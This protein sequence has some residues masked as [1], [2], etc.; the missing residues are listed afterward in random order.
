MEMNKLNVALQSY[1]IIKIEN[2]L[3]PRAV[4]ARSLSTD[5]IQKLLINAR[6]SGWY[7]NMELMEYIVNC[8]LSHE[9]DIR[10]SIKEDI[11]RECRVAREIWTATLRSIRKKLCLL[12]PLSKRFSRIDAVRKYRFSDLA[13][14]GLLYYIKRDMNN[15]N[16]HVYV[17]ALLESSIPEIKIKGKLL[18]R[19]ERKAFINKEKK[20]I[21]EWYLD[22]HNIEK[23]ILSRIPMTLFP[24]EEERF[25]V[26]IQLASTLDWHQYYRIVFVYN[27]LLEEL[28]YNSNQLGGLDTT[29]SDTNIITGM[30]AIF[31]HIVTPKSIPF[32]VCLALL[33]DGIRKDLSRFPKIE[34]KK[35]KTMVD[36]A[37]NATVMIIR[38]KQEES[39][40]EDI[41]LELLNQFALLIN[42]DKRLKFG[43]CFAYWQE[44]VAH[45]RKE[46]EKSAREFKEASQFLNIPDCY[47]LVE[48][49][50]D[51]IVFSHFLKLYAEYGIAI[52]V[53]ECG[54]KE[55]VDRRFRDLV[56]K[57]SYV[58]SIVTVLDADAG[59]QYDNLKRINIGN[60]LVKHFIYPQGTLEDLFSVKRHIK[61][62]N[63]LYPHGGSIGSLDLRGSKR[64]EKKINA[65]LWKK[66]SVHFD[67][68]SYAE[69]MIGE[70]KSRRHIPAKAREIVNATVDL[71]KARL[72]KL[73]KLHSYLSVDRLSREVLANIL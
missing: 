31:G 59:K 5:E 11:F 43:S 62:L 70:F 44:Y 17:Q 30:P 6:T 35:I 2:S 73:P 32:E 18:T 61:V 21:L 19:R 42:K 13:T 63:S 53:E 28:T 33:E 39:K 3:K 15:I 65:V 10:S 47:L 26:A 38:Q 58:G 4:R 68:K 57:E 46:I 66:K 64:I 54:S 34:Q 56:K 36:Q 55:G 27:L 12:L 14:P 71:A 45:Q 24:T 22:F 9:Q 29:L 1:S 49:I 69:A 67:K 23:N 7:G 16:V 60:L 8:G 51:K 50:S 48:G 52:R 40:K 41:A 20:G 72:K 37:R 25:Y